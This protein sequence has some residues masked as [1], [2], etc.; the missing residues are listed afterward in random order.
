MRYLGIV[1]M[2]VGISGS[3]AARP[4]FSIGLGAGGSSVGGGPVDPSS[5][6]PTTSMLSPIPAGYPL[7]TNFDGGVSALFTIASPDGV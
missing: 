6:T 7:T 2:A 4:G 5:L 3:A 1:L